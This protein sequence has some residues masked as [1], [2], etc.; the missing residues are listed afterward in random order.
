M[1]PI[2]A[3]SQFMVPVLQV[4]ADGEIRPLRDVRAA[5]AD[6]VGPTEDQLA[7]RFAASGEFVASNRI[8]W[9]GNTLARLGP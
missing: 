9:A 5:T 3:W 8:D 7:D 2:P 4:M 1:D 6:L